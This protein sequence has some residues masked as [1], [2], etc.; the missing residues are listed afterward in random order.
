[1]SRCYCKFGPGFYPF[2]FFV[3]PEGSD[4]IEDARDE[5]KE[6]QHRFSRKHSATEHKSMQRASKDL[7]K[8]IGVREKKVNPEC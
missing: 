6:L 4:V 2:F 1:M 3:F 8:E 5:L 7:R